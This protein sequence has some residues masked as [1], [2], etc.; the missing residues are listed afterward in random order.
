MRSQRM[1]IIKE[2]CNQL[3]KID[4]NQDTKN[5]VKLRYGGMLLKSEAENPNIF[6]AFQ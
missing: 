2:F 1:K 4:D 5:K 6:P 3:N